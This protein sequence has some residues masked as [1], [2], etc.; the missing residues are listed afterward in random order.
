MII[1]MK[2]TL[3]SRESLDLNSEKIEGF[4]KVDNFNND[5]AFGVSLFVFGDFKY[6]FPILIYSK[7]L[8]E[9]CQFF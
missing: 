2:W 5:I 4:Y 1:S 6:I 9:P 3:V 7:F 8:T